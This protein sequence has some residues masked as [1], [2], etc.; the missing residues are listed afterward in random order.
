MASNFNA[1]AMLRSNSIAKK[2]D[3]LNMEIIH[4]QS[5]VKDVLSRFSSDGKV[6]NSNDVSRWL[7]GLSSDGEI[8]DNELR[9]ILMLG[10]KHSKSENRYSGSMKNLDLEKV[11]LCPDSF[12]IVLESWITYIKN[13][14]TIEGIFQKFDVDRNG[15]LSRS[16]VSSMLAMLN[17]GALPSEEDT[18]WVITSAD[19]IGDCEGIETP[20]V[21][22]LIS[23]WYVRPSLDTIPEEENQN[24]KR[25]SC[26]APSGI[27]ELNDRDVLVDQA[28]TPPTNHPDRVSAGPACG[29]CA[30][31]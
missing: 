20:E 15:S 12:E 6:L 30:L 1:S 28:P 4:R 17:D 23:A 24:P 16:E 25:K 22:Q 2:Q 21:L 27:I 7:V 29:R 19:E 11:V 3:E 5:F 10:S 13:K 31:Q 18:E 26:V 9:W 8:N 14:P